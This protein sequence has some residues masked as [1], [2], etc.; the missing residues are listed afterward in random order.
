MNRIRFISIPLL[1]GIIVLLSICPGVRAADDVVVRLEASPENPWVG[2]KVALLLDVLGKDSWA[3]LKKVHDYELQ[4]G[5]LKRYESQGTR[6]NETID[7]ASYTG[8][9]YE[10]LFF[11]QRS[12]ALTIASMTIDVE[13]KHWGSNS[14]NEILRE[15]TPS[16]NLNVRTPS[17]MQSATGIVSTASF[18]V[19]QKW[20]P[21]LTE[22][23]A[24]DAVTRSV[25]FEADDV[26][27]MVLPEILTENTAGV[28]TYPKSPLV[29]DKYSRGDLTGIREETITYVMEEPGSHQLQELMFPWFNIETEEIGTITLAGRTFTVSA[30]QGNNDAPG[31]ADALTAK[32]DRRYLWGFAGLFVLTLFF[33]FLWKYVIRAWYQVWM[34]KTAQS[35]KNY[36][37]RVKNA[38]RSVDPLDL[39]NAAM[40]WLDRISVERHPPRLDQFAARYGSDDDVE[41]INAFAA[42]AGSQDPSIQMESF[43]ET[44][45]KL[46]SNWLTAEKRQRRIQNAEQILP[47]IGID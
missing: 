29:D 28:G 7:G 19:T 35:E 22:L 34:D 17:G 31:A 40:Q 39:M 10:F 46:R 33:S 32:A 5:Y 20:E 25:I 2:Q 15:T 3:Q 12:G 16:L 24:G 45:V 4:G 21:E 37:T 44:L 26:S 43:Y 41:Y 38:S 13:V 18:S 23:A 9:R 8:Q 42:L 11:P 36:F 1:A 30:V 14:S 6:L 27:G 47:Q